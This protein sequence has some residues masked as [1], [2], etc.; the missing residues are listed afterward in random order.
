M[1]EF[2]CFLKIDIVKHWRATVR[3]Q[4]QGPRAMMT[5][6]EAHLTDDSRPLT[7]STNLI[8]TVVDWVASG[9]RPCIN[10]TQKTPEI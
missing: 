7:G 5:E 1:G 3:V 2:K 8:R 9:S 10:G 4:R 6:L